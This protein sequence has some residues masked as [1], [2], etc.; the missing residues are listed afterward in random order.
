MLV[1]QDIKLPLE[2][3]QLRGREEKT[4]NIRGHVTKG[5]L[6]THQ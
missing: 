3:E 5:K 1:T 2:I 6:C 4:Q